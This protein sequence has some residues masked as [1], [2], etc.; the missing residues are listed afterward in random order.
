MPR[1]RTSP[2]RRPGP[3]CPA[4]PG[5]GVS[6]AARARKAAAA[7]APPRACARSAERSSSP[8]TPRRHPLPPGRDAT[9][10]D[11]DRHPDRSPPPAPDARFA[12]PQGQPT[13][14][15]RSAP[16]DG[17]TARARR[18]RAAAPP[19]RDPGAD[20]EP[21]GSAPEQRRIPGGSAAATS[22]RRRASSESARPPD[23]ALLDMARE[24]RH[25]DKPEA[26]GQLRGRQAPW[27]LHQRERVPARL[28]D[29]PVAD[30]VVDPNRDRAPEQGAGVL[31]AQAAQLQFGQGKCWRH[32]LA[33]REHDPDRLRQQATGDEG[34]R[35]RRRLIEPLRV[36]HE[37]QQRTFLGHLRQQAQHR[38][39]DEEPIRDQPGRQ[40]QATRGAPAAA[41]EARR[42]DRAW[43]HRTDACSRT[44]APSLTP[45][46]RARPES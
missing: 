12:A 41:P 44:A 34:E 24:I 13:G 11:R 35:Q 8:A 6:S 4:P 19:P 42:A 31:A 28:G 39:S 33:D 22:S 43:A 38:Q 18:A 10:G 27:Q 14:R 26:A 30:L 37:T 1:H 29:D 16:A 3:A 46:R 36:I 32:R 20:P 9:P 2:A 5:S 7:A 25:R 15:R 23:E 45:R 40:A 21:L 17:G